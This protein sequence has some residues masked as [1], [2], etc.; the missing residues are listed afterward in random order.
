MNGIQLTG[1][2]K[3]KRKKDGRTYLSGKVNRATRLLVLPND[4]KEKDSDPDF[5]VFLVPIEEEPQTNGTPNNGQ[6]ESGQQWQQNRAQ[7][8]PRPPDRSV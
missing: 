3:C 5:N 6:R 7:H 4:R 2:Y 1:L 8:P